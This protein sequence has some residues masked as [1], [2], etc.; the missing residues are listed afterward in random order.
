[1]GV[2]E[3][4]LLVDPLTGVAVP[5][6]EEVL[7]RLDE[8]NLPPGASVAQ[9]L[10]LTQ[11]ETV[12]GIC[13]TADE[14]RAHLTVGR[15]LLGQSAAAEHCVVAATGTPYGPASDANH[16]AGERRYDDINEIYQG[17][18]S[19]YDACG[20][21]VHIGVPDRD[22]AVAVVNHVGRWLPTLLAL[23]A[24]SPFDHERDT[25]YH[26]WRMVLQSRFPGSGIAPW[27][28]GYR[29]YRRCL[30]TLVDCGA[31]VDEHQTFWL[32]RPSARLPTVELRVADTAITV[33]DALLQGLLSRALVRTALWE[34][35][36]GREADAID[37][38]VTAAAVW[39]ASRYG[40]TGAGVDPVRQQVV[41]ATA[42]LSALLDHVRDALAESGDLDLVI[43]LTGRTVRDGNGA[44]RQRRA[45]GRGGCPAVHRM[46]AKHTIPALPAQ[47]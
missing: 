33:D 37:Q 46:L 30:E 18:V 22:T 47:A 3:E 31:L 1:M 20:C 13:T 45:A 29:E 32:A 34:L 27:F 16:T 10:R 14:L 6:A 36:Q 12:T 8:D 5:R 7:A 23:S 44:T 43:E 42:L 15:R 39:S 35:A 2:E 4:F 26:S 41:P 21:H 25:G 38:Q 9:E 28:P 11:A 17:I 40:L 19:D 24:N